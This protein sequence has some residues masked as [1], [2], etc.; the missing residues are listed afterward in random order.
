MQFLQ[1]RNDQEAVEVEDAP[2][3]THAINIPKPARY[4]P[5]MKLFKLASRYRM[6]ARIVRTGAS[7]DSQVQTTPA[8]TQEESI[9]AVNSHAVREK[10]I[11]RSSVEI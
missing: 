2:N 10:I 7:N 5:Q 9:S 8:P 4:L 11:A 3:V 6:V 1:I